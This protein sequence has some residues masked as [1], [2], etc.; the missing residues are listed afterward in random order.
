MKKLKSE[1]D[2][3][4]KTKGKDKKEIKQ[5]KGKDADLDANEEKGEILVLGK[6]ESSLF[7]KNTG[8]TQAPHRRESHRRVPGP[9][10]YRVKA[11]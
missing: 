9:S 3:N 8:S 10:A 5:T 2:K 6:A 4:E 1:I 11:F 7:Y